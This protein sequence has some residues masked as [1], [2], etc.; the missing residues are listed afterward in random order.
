MNKR[1]KSQIIEVLERLTKVETL[2]ELGFKQNTKDHEEIKESIGH[3]KKEYEILEQRV[4]DLEHRYEK[5]LIY[6]KLMALLGSP[7]V[8]AVIVA[9]AFKFLGL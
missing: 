8:S 7:I 2:I 6:W 1:E 9:V 5:R 4:D 3:R